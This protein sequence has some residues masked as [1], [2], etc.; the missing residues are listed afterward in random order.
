MKK[1]NHIA[2][3]QDVYQKLK[4][5]GKAGDSFNDVIIQILQVLENKKESNKQLSM[6]NSR[7]GTREW[8]LTIDAHQFNIIKISKEVQYYE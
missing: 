5:L 6:P 2:V 4:N 8:T 7:V 3:D 1:L